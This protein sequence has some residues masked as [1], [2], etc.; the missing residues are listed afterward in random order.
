MV[1]GRGTTTLRV[2]DTYDHTRTI[3]TEGNVE[4]HVVC[5]FTGLP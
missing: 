3:T 5:L 1:T 2:P 4:H